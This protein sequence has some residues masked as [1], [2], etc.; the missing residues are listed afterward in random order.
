MD[1]MNTK[2]K[3]IVTVFM[4]NT[5]LHRFGMSWMIETYEN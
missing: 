4:L 2:Y 1:N 3:D 5:F